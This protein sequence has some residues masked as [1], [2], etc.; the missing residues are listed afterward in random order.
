[1][2]PDN[3]TESLEQLKAE[4]HELKERSCSATFALLSK[5]FCFIL[6]SYEL[7]TCLFI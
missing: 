2:L 3:L 7:S 1:M 5:L 6:G 4:N